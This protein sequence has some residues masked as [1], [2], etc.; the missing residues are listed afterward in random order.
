LKI[1]GKDELQLCVA[2]AMMNLCGAWWSWQ[3]AAVGFAY[4]LERV[5]DATTMDTN[6]L[7]LLVIVM[8]DTARWFTAA[9]EVAEQL[10]ERGYA[11]VI[12]VAWSQP[13]RKR[14]RCSAPWSGCGGAV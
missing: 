3:H 14:A 13:E 12:D 7:L 9:L 4:G 6:A 1:S 2:G 10:R 11:A 5:A 8:A